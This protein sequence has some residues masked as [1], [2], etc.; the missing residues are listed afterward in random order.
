M[1]CPMGGPD[2]EDAFMER[3]EVYVL[4]LCG[5]DKTPRGIINEDFSRNGEQQ[6]IVADGRTRIYGS[7]GYCRIVVFQ[8]RIRHATTSI[9]GKP[10]AVVSLIE[11]YVHCF[12]ECQARIGGVVDLPMCTIEL[13]DTVVVASGQPQVAPS[14]RLNVPNRVAGKRRVASSVSGD[15]S[16][17]QDRHPQ[18]INLRIKAAATVKP[19]PIALVY[20]NTG[21]I[22]GC[23]A[24]PSGVSRE[25]RA[26]K[27]NQATA[28][29]TAPNTVL[30]V[31]VK[32]I[33]IIGWKIGVGCVVDFP[34]PIVTTDQPVGGGQ[35]QAAKAV[36]THLADV[37]VGERTVGVQVSRG[38]GG[39]YFYKTSVVVGLYT[40]KGLEP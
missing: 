23:K 28:K 15:A 6:M 21:D 32:A 25:P 8:L 30:A 4:S 26:V 19:N 7:G 31:E 38:V 33:D 40:L 27:A 20:A 10:D 16:V 35:P 18:A 9:A 3:A 39:G 36:N 11:G 13:R 12:V 5:K 22:I 1:A 24:L 29:S 14:I 34:L 17:A 37:I 2:D